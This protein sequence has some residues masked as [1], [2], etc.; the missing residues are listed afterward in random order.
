MT[1]LTCSRCGSTGT[2][3][4]DWNYEFKSGSLI[5]VICPRCQ[6]PEENAEAEIN[7][8]TLE[9]GLDSRG[10]PAARPKA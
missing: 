6:T 5:A 10:R 9:Y 7:E 2:D 3:R 4:G 1:K 8:A